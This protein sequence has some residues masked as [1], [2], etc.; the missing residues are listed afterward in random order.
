MGPVSYLPECPVFRTREVPGFRPSACPDFMK[1]HWKT[2]LILASLGLVAPLVFLAAQAPAEQSQ[3]KVYSKSRGPEIEFYASNEYLVPYQLRAYFTKL[4]GLKPSHPVPYYVVLRPGQ[5]ETFLFSLKRIDSSQPAGYKLLTDAHP[6]DPKQAVHD[7]THLYLL[8]FE[9]GAKYKL[10]QG[11]NGTTSH[12]APS[13]YS[14]DFIMDIGTK[15]MAA[16][17]GLVFRVKEDSN[18]GGPGPRY[19]R[20]ANEIEVYHDD[21]S[22]AKYVHLK[23]GGSLV[24][25]GDRVKA[26]QV[27]GLSGNTGWSTGPHL[28]F[29]VIVPTQMGYRS[30]PTRFRGR[31]ESEIALEEGRY[32]YAYHPGG[33]EFE[34]VFGAALTDSNFENH[35]IAVN[36]GSGVD[37]RSEREDDTIIVFL[38]NGYP[39]P[40][41]IHVT[42]NL[43]NLRA[44]KQLP[45]IRRVPA[46][47]EVYLLLL[48][49]IDPTR[50]SAFSAEL[51]IKTLARSVPGGTGR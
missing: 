1:S 15:I 41:E 38:R 50:R 19:S 47:S 17:D 7:D 37:I 43:V 42:L 30:V 14:L 49:P 5:K 21:G 3:V 20:H 4:Y 48:R 9:H 36:P 51:R 25:V 27:I 46:A 28:H 35:S 29:E 13:Q 2:G 44:S 18:I 34:E 24:A 8:P 22:I 11:Y 39:R 45:V 31:D 12:S 33:A 10:A 16:R 40:R 6:G 26:G 32:Y 23:Q